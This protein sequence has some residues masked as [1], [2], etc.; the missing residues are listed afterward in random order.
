MEQT[1]PAGLRYTMFASQV[2]EKQIDLGYVSD[3]GLGSRWCVSTCGL[4]A[5]RVLR[6]YREKVSV[7]E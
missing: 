1:G 2:V 4:L 7:Y 5:G 6:Q 3:P